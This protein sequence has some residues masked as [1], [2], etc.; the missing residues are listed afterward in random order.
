MRSRGLSDSKIALSGCIRHLMDFR[1]TESVPCCGAM[2]EHSGSATT[3]VE[4]HGLMESVFTITTRRMDSRT[5][6]CGLWLRTPGRTFGLEPGAAG[7]ILFGMVLSPTTAEST[8][9]RTI[10]WYALSPHGM[11][12]SGLRPRPA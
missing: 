1:I 12:H 10:S 8:A 4:S 7:S 5:H 3:A 2:T 9:C 11:D 6:V